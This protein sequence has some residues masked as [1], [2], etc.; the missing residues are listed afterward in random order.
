MCIFAKQDLTT[1]PPFS[2][3]DLICCRNV[4]IYFDSILQE[5]IIPAL[6]CALKPNGFLI[7]GE[8][9]SIGRF[10]DLFSP[11]EKKNS[12]YVRKQ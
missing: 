6:H 4:L 5:K 2:N 7:L 3:L 8:S 11:I 9:E 12:I 10:T 1:D